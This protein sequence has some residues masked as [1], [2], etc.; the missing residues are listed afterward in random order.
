MKVTGMNT[1]MNTQVQEISHRHVT[2]RIFRRLIGRVVSGIKFRLYGF[3]HYDGVI[4]HRTDGKHQGKQGQDVQIV[5]PAAARQA[6]V[7]TNDTMMEMDGISV[8]LKS[9]RKKY[10]T[11]ITRMIATISVSTTL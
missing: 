10:T 3:Y 1:A 8:L 9:C 4:H 6:N 11:R 7:P 2:H 5:N